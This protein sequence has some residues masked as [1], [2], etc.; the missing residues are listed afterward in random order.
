MSGLICIFSIL[1]SSK[2]NYKIIGLLSWFEKIWNYM[3]CCLMYG[4]ISIEHLLSEF[5]FIYFFWRIK[6]L[7]YRKHYE[8]M[9]DHRHEHKRTKENV[10]NLQLNNKLANNMDKSRISAKKKENYHKKW[11]HWQL[12]NRKITDKVRIIEIREHVVENVVSFTLIDL[13]WELNRL[14]PSYAFC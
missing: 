7:R 10:Q 13:D 4:F 3:M 9:E 6:S 14:F 11:K 1:K 2:W 5:T 8:D 12:L